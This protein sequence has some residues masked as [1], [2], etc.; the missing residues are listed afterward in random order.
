MRRSCSARCRWRTE[1]LSAGTLVAFL[2]TALTLRWPVESFGFLLALS[3]ESA[4]ATDRFF[5]VMDEPVPPDV[6]RDAEGDTGAAR[7]GLCFEGV[8]FR[9]PDASAGTPPVPHG[10][11]L[12]VR[13]GETMALVGAT[14]S[15]RPR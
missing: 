7:E 10:I 1:A 5:E 3:N 9:Y 4:T 8:R 2:S 6:L 14:G 12:H 13:S 15:G 11:D